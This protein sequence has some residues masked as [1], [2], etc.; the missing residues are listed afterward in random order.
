MEILDQQA[1]KGKGMRMLLLHSCLAFSFQILQS[2]HT[3]KSDTM[4]RLVP[5]QEV[6]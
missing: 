5:R 4:Q 6:T 3:Q 1:E 2:R